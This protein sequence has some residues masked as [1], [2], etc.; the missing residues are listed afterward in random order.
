MGRRCVVGAVG[1]AIFGVVLRYIEI[2]GGDSVALP[3]HLDAVSISI[4]PYG[5]HSVITL[6]GH[7][8]E[9]TQFIENIFPT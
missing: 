1:V 7:R 2:V 6:F 9:S 4:S 8:A 3:R 5:R